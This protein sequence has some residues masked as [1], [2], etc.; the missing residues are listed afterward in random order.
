VLGSV[1]AGASSQARRCGGVENREYEMGSNSSPLVSV[2]TPVYNNQ[3]YLAECIESVLAQTYQN[4]DYTIVNN[5]CTDGSAE[6]AHRYAAKD[7]RIKVHDNAQFLR[8][9]PNHNLAL[10]QIS[11]ESKYCKIVFADDWIFPRCLEEMVSVA[12]EN[13]SV[14]IVGAYGLEEVGTGASQTHAVMWTGL[15]YPARRIS[16]REVCRRLFWDGT[17]VFGTSTS[18]LYRADLVRSRDPFYNEANLHADAEACIEL[19]KICD[20]GFVHQVLTFKRWRPQSLGT[21]S[22][23]FQTYFAHRLHDLVTYGPHFLTKEEFEVCIGRALGEYYNFLAVSCMRGRRDKKFWNYHKSKLSEAGVGFSRARLGRAIAARLCRAVLNPYETIE[24]LKKRQNHRELPDSKRSHRI[25]DVLTSR[26]DG[27]GPDARL[28]TKPKIAFFGHFGRGNFGNES[29]LQAIL[30]YLR[31]L[32]PDAG[33]NCICTGPEIVAT[34]Y[35]I[36]AAPCRDLVIKSWPPRHPLA[37]L[38]R[39]LVVGIP[40]ELYRWLKCLRTLWGVDALV[41]PGT[42]LLTDAYGLLNWGPYDMFR[43]SVAAKLCRCKLF[44]I[45]V[46]AGPIYTRA[47]RFFVRAALSLADFRSYRD[48]STLQYLKGIGFRVGNDPVYPDLAFSLSESLIP[49]RR[50]SEGLRLVVG[51]G[52]MF[53]A[54]KYSVERP[55][56]AVYSAYLETL[57]EL[58]K[59]LL[60]REYNVRLL[61]GDLADTRVTREFRS[62]LQERSVMHEEARVIDEP[63]ASVEDLLEQ[64]AATDFVVA[65]RFHN[66]LLSLLLNKPVLAI[67]FHHKCSSLMRQMGLSEYC[68]DINCLNADRLI[69]Q[70]CN[71][72]RNA[73]R[74]RS[75]IK[76][77]TEE[78][79]RALDDQYKL[80]FKEL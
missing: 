2:V 70:F 42:G 40:S 71:L 8:A 23:D 49:R 55:T 33:F 75:L 63:V 7:S 59:W 62:L 31:R 18:L 65:T 77:K 10:R 67:S 73:E 25:K 44:F 32:A 38:A 19:L 54:G 27:N 16:G 9:V 39:K 66:V 12:E 45:S 29:T 3:E 6:I 21:F 13:P 34:A 48:E 1:N 11:S 57:V 4:W 5:C 47:G 26:L 51:L 58:V 68:Q 56:S 22:L 37:R 53:Y 61:I 24:K 41:V 36:T 72:E 52:L 74:L 80:I 64:I 46:G 60:A 43:W 50:D 69:E 14:G 35:N 76:Q 79:R 17:Y 20:F 78:F 30:Y 28:K 15:P